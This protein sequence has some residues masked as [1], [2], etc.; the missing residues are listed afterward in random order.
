MAVDVGNAPFVG[1]AEA[2]AALHRRLEDA[3]SGLGGVTLLVGATGVGKSVLVAQLLREMRERGVRV[4]TTRASLGD[5]P[6]PF[7]LLQPLLEEPRGTSGGSSRGEP[8]GT[9]ERILIG[10]APGLKA[11]G[12]LEPP[13]LEERLLEALGEPNLAPEGDRDRVFAGL[14]DRFFEHTRH[15]PTVLVVDDLHRADLSSLDALESL[16]ERLANRPLWILATVRP[17]SELTPSRRERLER[18]EETTRARRL[19]LPSLASDEVGEFLRRIDPEREFT[20]EELQRRYSETGGN[21]LLLELLDQRVRAPAGPGGGEGPGPDGAVVVPLPPTLDAIEE[22]ALA[23]ASVIGLNV[24][25]PLLVRAA[26]E[27]EE[28]LAEAVDR[29]VAR[30]LL[31][32]R[33]NELLSFAEE[34]RRTE[35]YDQLLPHRREMLHRRVGDALEGDGVND[36]ETIYALARHFYLGKDDAKSLRYNRAAA[37]IAERVYAPEVAR[38]HLERALENL[39]RHAPDDVLGETELV[40]ELAQQL[41]HAGNLKEAE[42]SLRHH[43]R[44]RRLEE[45]VPPPLRGLGEV[46]LVRIQANRGD[47]AG[48]DEAAARLLSDPAFQDLP[49]IRAALHRLRGEALYYQGRYAPALEEHTEELRLARATGNERAAALGRWRRASTL[50]MMG[51]TAEA[52]A[53]GRTAAADL[54]RIG[55]L[56][57]A[58]HAHLFLGVIGASLGEDRDRPETALAE[59]DQ[60][61]ALGEKA[62][63]PRRVAWALFNAADVLREA[64]RLDEAT[65]RN[66][67][68]RELLERIGDRFG[69]VQ[70]HIVAGK[71]LLA[72]HAFGRAEEELREAHRLV[73]ELKAPADQ[74]DV[75]LRLAELAHARGDLVG[76]RRQVRELERQDLPGLRPDIVA[77]FERLRKALGEAHGT[78]DG[79]A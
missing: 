48:A 15:G 1:R 55:D 59:F 10:F 58:S 24:P 65:E 17:F 72:Q 75:E 4:F 36:V 79:T 3:V 51:A 62:R 13:D 32:E 76:A 57:E 35:T 27:D 11:P 40:L 6:P 71:V 31:L 29:L 74:I 41:D 78:K 64:G 69:L 22:Q 18:F 23:A 50:A 30:G 54:E 70:S 45:R 49:G 52:L 53:E 9:F 68:A 21:P 28:R 12:G 42:A 60:A 38:A 2:V 47:W 19:A 73:Q 46:Y 8:A 56:R 7:S 16:A 67:R 44:R 20:E 43:L 14:S 39:R 33:P 77:D 61:K 34:R 63:D 25:F 5:A 37:G 66:A 26:G